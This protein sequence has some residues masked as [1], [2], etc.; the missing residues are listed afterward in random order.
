VTAGAASVIFKIN[1]F[2]ITKISR[3]I[4]VKYNQQSI[5]QSFFEVEG[6]DGINITRRHCFIAPVLHNH[7][8]ERESNSA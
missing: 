3:G 1:I 2:L 6:G 8:G 5:I 4:K 7:V